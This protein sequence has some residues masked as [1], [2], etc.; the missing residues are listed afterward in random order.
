MEK[1]ILITIGHPAHVHYFKNAVRILKS[2]GWEALFFIRDRE[3]IIDLVNKLDFKYICYGKG[4]SNLFSKMVDIPIIDYK[5]LKVALKFKPDYFLSFASPYAAHVATILRIPHI[6][7]DDTEHAKLGHLLYQPFSDVI[8]SP[9]VWNSKLHKRQ[10]LFHSFM[11]LFYLHKN[12]FIPEKD[13]LRTIGLTNDDK[14]CVIRFIS[15]NANHDVGVKGL[16][17]ND[18]NRIVK[19]LSKRCKV[20]I[21]SESQLPKELENYK[22][23]TDPS[24]FH[25]VMSAATLCISEG[26][27]TASESA[28]LGTPTIYVNPLKVS[29]CDEEEKYG[30]LYQTKKADD[31][32]L[33][34]LDILSTPNVKNQYKIKRDRLLSQMIDGTAFLTWF[35]ENYPESKKIIKENPDYQYIF[36]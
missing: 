9:Y 2:K 7:F 29:N 22:L 11:E 17:V 35:M 27:T 12:Y 1:R 26:S 20:F 10:Y 21:S 6:A 36:K 28:L 31:I 3:C 8:L 18:K 33:K 24:L 15:W 16:S 14:F 25:S 5:L 4:G 34:S 13:C 32:I 30:L 19:E 23:T